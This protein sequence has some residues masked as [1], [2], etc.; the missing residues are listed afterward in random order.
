MLKIDV[1]T[2]ILPRDIPQWKDKF[3]YGGFIQLEHNGPGCARMV[4]DDGHFFREIE[5]NCWDPR[6]RIVEIDGSAVNVQ[7]LST[8]PVMF[9]YWAKP[10]DGLEIARYINHH[11]AAMVNDFPAALVGLGTVPMQDTQLAVKELE[12]CKAMGLAGVEIGTNVNQLESRRQAISRILSACEE[13]E[14]A[15]FVHPWDMMGRSRYAGIL[16]AVA[17]GNAGRNIPGDLLA[18]IFRDLGT[19]ASA[20]NMFRSRRRCFPRHDRSHRAR[21]QRWAGPLRSR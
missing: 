14:M 3:G 20:A 1:H 9:S 21:L 15:V 12:S 6:K 17:C 16:A 5:D 10:A 19:S 8:V 18:D 13:L 11:I 4:K 2:H 7:V